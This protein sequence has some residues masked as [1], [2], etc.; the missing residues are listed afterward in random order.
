MGII[1]ILNGAVGYDKKYLSIPNLALER[2]SLVALIGK[3]GSGKSTF[4]KTLC[5]LI[6]VFEGDFRVD[7]FDFSTH[8]HRGL[9]KLVAFVSSNQQSI[10]YLTVNEF[11]LLGRTPHTGMLGRYS[12]TDY[13]VAQ[14][15]INSFNIK[16]L[17]KKEL[18]DLSDGER[19]LAAFARSFAQET[20]I[21]LMDEPTAF[22]DYGNKRALLRQLR[23]VT[24]NSDKC[25]LFSTH[26]IDLCLEERIQLIGIETST[27]SLVQL[28]NTCSKE[29]IL[30]RIF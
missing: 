11:V 13:K 20:P 5:G 10:P 12:S 27:K 25:V 19:Q 15:A 22:L 16:H 2:G 4:L 29:T 17:E 9:S 24:S 7:T 18:T 14:L 3:N 1:R 21:I 23:E 8:S 30:T 6:P 26:D 28:E